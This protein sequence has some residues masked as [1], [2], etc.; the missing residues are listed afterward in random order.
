MKDEGESRAILLGAVLGA[1]SGATFAVLYRRWT[2]QRRGEAGRPIQAR[3]MMRLGTSLVPVVRQILQ[4]LSG[5][6]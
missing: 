5:S 3:Q 2:R 4:L 1:L 6:A